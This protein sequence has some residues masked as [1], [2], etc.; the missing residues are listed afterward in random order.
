MKLFK[1]RRIKILQSR[2]W[3]VAFGR[4]IIK[5]PLRY[6]MKLKRALLIVDLQNDFCRGGAL[7]VPGGEEIVAPLNGYIR[8]FSKLKLPIFAS[9]DWHPR[10][11]AHFKRF[12]GTW[13]VHCV[14]NTQGARFRKDLQ[15]PKEAIILSKGVEMDEDSYSVFQAKDTDGLDFVSLL[16]MFGVTE[17][18]VGGLATDYC[19]K[20]SVLDALKNGFKVKL[21]A[22]AI[23][24]VNL[25][26]AD[27]REAINEMAAKGAI[28]TDFK[29]VSRQLSQRRQ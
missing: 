6:N 21:L 19:V 15:L 18:Y 14:A 12:G 9:R 29:N 22:D 16:K 10:N 8:I 24:G 3:I 28:K 20:Y 11:T 27:S 4:D 26:P 25:K 17:L 23:Q 13:P 2:D 7:A 1:T 5:N